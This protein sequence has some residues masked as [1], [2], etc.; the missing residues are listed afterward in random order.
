MEITSFSRTIDC[1]SF[2]ICSLI[3]IESKR[4]S[5]QVYHI[6]S[7]RFLSNVFDSPES[8]SLSLSRKQW[9]SFTERRTNVS[10]RSW[11]RPPWS[12]DQPSMTVCTIRLKTLNATRHV[13]EGN[14][15]LVTD[16]P[17]TTPSI[18]RAS[19]SNSTERI[20]SLST[21]RRE[22]DG[23]YTTQVDPVKRE[24][25]VWEDPSLYNPSIG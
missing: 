18:S 5:N 23:T 10:F 6:K 25:F 16:F 22:I 1:N 4:E 13:R 17:G 9:V 11:N 3:F 12:W 15:K 21:K 14:S 20:R 7:R 19:V 2:G 24:T 8:M